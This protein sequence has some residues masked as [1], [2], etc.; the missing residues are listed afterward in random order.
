MG[1]PNGTIPRPGRAYPLKTGAG[2]YVRDEGW[3]QDEWVPARQMD[4]FAAKGPYSLQ[5]VSLIKS[6]PNLLSVRGE[7]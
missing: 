4:E 3:R 7:G 2:L 5:E 6:S 1:A